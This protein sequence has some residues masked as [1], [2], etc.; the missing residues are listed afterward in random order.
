MQGMKFQ[1]DG[2]GRQMFCSVPV[3]YGFYKK[4]LYM[5]MKKKQNDQTARLRRFM[6]HVT[7]DVASCVYG[8]SR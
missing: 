7:H 6:L 5:G 4:L 2:Y 1:N 8:V 3:Q